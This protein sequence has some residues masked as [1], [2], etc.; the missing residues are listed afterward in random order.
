MRRALLATVL[1]L[2]LAAGAGAAGSSWS[3]AALIQTCAPAATPQVVFPSRDPQHRSGRG[4]ILWVGGRPRCGGAAHAGTTLDVATLHADDE[5]SFARALVGGAGVSAPLETAMTTHGQIVAAAGARGVASYGETHAS[6]AL[7]AL[8]PIGG[9][10]A[11]VATA[12]GYIGDA[13]LVDVVRSGGAQ[14]VELREQRHYATAFGKP[15][16]FTVGGAAIATITVGMDFR[17]DSIVVWSQGGTLYSRW[18]T[19]KGRV[20]AA[21]TLGPGGYAPQVATVLSDNNHAFVLWSDEPPPGAAGTA[22]LYLVHSG[23]DATFTPPK[24]SLATFEEPAGQRLTAGSLALVRMSPSEGVLAAWTAIGP[25]GDYFVSV[26]GVTSGGALPPGTVATPG[27]DLRLA[28]LAAGPRDDAVAVFESAARTARG[29]DSTQ[30]AILAARTVPGGPGGEALETP[31]QL[32]GPGP[33]GAPAVAIDPATDRAVVVWQTATSAGM[34]AIAYA[35][36]AP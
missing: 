14:Q 31:V 12:N 29:F 5:P 20:G 2:V 16:D 17:G 30:Q 8:T 27:V 9:D 25:S 33:N 24:H 22:V 23:D 7:P 26:A 18:I 15:I 6:V 4:A 3:A 28:A 1:L 11:L 34:P 21:Q 36:R 10:P 19:N 13:D 35:E 32:A